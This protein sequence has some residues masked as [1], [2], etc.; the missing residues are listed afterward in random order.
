MGPKLLT[1]SKHLW[2]LVALP[3]FGRRP[4]VSKL[5]VLQFKR[6]FKKKKKIFVKLIS[7]CMGPILA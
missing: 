5:L 4:L 3:H 7:L 2:K 6:R 1:W